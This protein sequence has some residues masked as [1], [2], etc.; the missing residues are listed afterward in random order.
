MARHAFLVLA[1]IA[2]LLGAPPVASAAGNALS[3]PSATPTTGTTQTVFVLRVTYDGQFPA[4]GVTAV[5]GGRALA[6]SLVAGSASSGTWSA[7]ATL[8]AGTW[9]VLYTA[10]VLQG[11]APSLSGLSLTVYGAA[12]PPPTPVS[13]VVTNQPR[14]RAGGE[15]PTSGGGGSTPAPA[16]AQ[17]PATGTP[18]PTP[19]AAPAPPAV[20]DD[21]GP[22][23]GEATPEHPIEAAAPSSAP[24]PAEGDGLPDGEATGDTLA[25]PTGAPASG[26]DTGSPTRAPG[27]DE[28]SGTPTGPPGTAE[29]PRDG[30]MAAGTDAPRPAE[31]SAG[32]A[33]DDHLPGMVLLLGLSGAAAVALAGS[34]LLMAGRRRRTAERP[35]LAAQATA[36]P[37]VAG[38]ARRA[39]RL[40]RARHDEDPIIASLGIGRTRPP[41]NPARS[42]T[43]RS[44]PK[45]G[46]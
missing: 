37:D 27:T 5:V 14:T 1:I 10:A 34:A 20:T 28:D 2:A 35:A 21:G 12:A 3:S 8:P 32:V 45:D 24:A 46:S 11:N 43:E 6:M 13:N 36:G 19:N 23:G 16:P 31:E 41:A 4:T 9:P 26:E 22:S 18:A 33:S 29:P 38:M 42:R 25:T 39:R 44:K 30:V 17:A 15:A 40:A 7:A